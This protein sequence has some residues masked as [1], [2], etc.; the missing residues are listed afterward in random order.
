MQHLP[1]E[2]GSEEPSAPA[3]ARLVPIGALIMVVAGFC[4]LGWGYGL[5]C[6]AAFR[7]PTLTV[8]VGLCTGL[9]CWI[10]ATFLLARARS[11]EASMT[12]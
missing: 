11:A 8:A 10:T 9:A 1:A 3:D 7:G 2:P 12:A 5:V 4:W 6:L